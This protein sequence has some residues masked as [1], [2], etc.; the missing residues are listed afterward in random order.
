MKIVVVSALLAAVFC[1]GVTVMADNTQ[2]PVKSAN[3]VVSQGVNIAE[4]KAADENISGDD[5]GEI[6]LDDKIGAGT[7]DKLA[8][9]SPVGDNDSTG[10]MNAVPSDSEGDI[11]D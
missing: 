5:T 3:A 1:F 2:A 8:A 10:L 9:Q 4:D 6:P 11:E 7:S